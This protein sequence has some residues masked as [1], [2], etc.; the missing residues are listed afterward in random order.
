MTISE[1][2]TTSLVF[3]LTDYQDQQAV[4]TRRE[5]LVEEIGIKVIL[6]LHMI[7]PNTTVLWTE[8]FRM[9]R[10]SISNCMSTFPTSSLS[11][12]NKFLIPN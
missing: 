10:E 9:L 11:K 6:K 4:G 12:L 3:T 2:L 7:K 1:E 5:D 8:T